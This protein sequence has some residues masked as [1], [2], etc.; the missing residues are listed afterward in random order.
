MAL[1][2]YNNGIL[3]DSLDVDFSNSENI[4]SLVSKNWIRRGVVVDRK[5]DNKYVLF[6][7]NDS[8]SIHFGMS[9]EI[10]YNELL[11]SNDF[12][13]TAKR[14]SR[15]GTSPKDENYL[16]PK[17]K[18]KLTKGKKN[19]NFLNLDNEQFLIEY[20]T[21]KELILKIKKGV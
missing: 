21:E 11:L 17:G 19:Q 10:L 7:S 9:L 6:V 15:C 8:N 12:N 4:Q 14:I 2:R 5:N 3:S 20:L 18:W 13:F 16:N 1:K